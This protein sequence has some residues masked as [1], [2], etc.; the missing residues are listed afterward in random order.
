MIELMQGSSGGIRP[1]YPNSGPGIKTLQYGDEQLGYFGE[2][3]GAE[4]FTANEF[5]SLAKAYFGTR[6]TV[7]DTMTQLGRFFIG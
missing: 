2:V 7:P 5:I 6:E 4:L 1:S 3:T